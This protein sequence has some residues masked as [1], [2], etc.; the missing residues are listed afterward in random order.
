VSE[1]EA[2]VFLSSRTEFC[3][4]VAETGVKG[5]CLACNGFIWGGESGID[6]TLPYDTISE[7]VAILNRKKNMSF[8]SGDEV[9]D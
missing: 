8:E 1:E 6:F 2:S 7:Y 3:V 5:H 9:A 4:P